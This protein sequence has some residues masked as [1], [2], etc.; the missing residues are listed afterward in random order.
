MIS[1]QMKLFGGNN[2]FKII[3]SILIVTA[4]TAV[5][6][7]I[8]DG[9][10]Q[11]SLQ[12]KELQ[13]AL[14]QLENEIMYTLTALPEACQRVAERS[15]KPIGVLFEKIS[16]K[17]K[18]NECDS[19]YNA[20]CEEFENVKKDLFINKDDINIIL[21]LAKTLGD[22]DMDGHKK[23]FK[24]AGDYLTSSINEAEIKMANSTKMYRT[25]GFS[26]GAAVVILLV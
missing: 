23:M 25:L 24:L 16:D 6:F 3:G 18:N 8:A 12:L 2:M 19:V 26:F 17:L 4:S 9:L 10:R 22:S 15:K 7:M 11:R 21:D 1:E 20:F 14:L 13:R 5:G